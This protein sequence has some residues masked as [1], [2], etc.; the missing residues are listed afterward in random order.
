MTA[1]EIETVFMQLGSF[2]RFIQNN[3]DF[4]QF[5]RTMELAKEA[6]LAGATPDPEFTDSGRHRGVDVL[7]PL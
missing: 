2:G 1:I 4:V 6:A 7:L 3:S 5:V